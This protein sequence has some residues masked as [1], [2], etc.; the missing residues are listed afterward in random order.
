MLPVV[1]MI[2]IYNIFS[3]VIRSIL[4]YEMC[5]KFFLKMVMNIDIKLAITL[6]KLFSMLT[7]DIFVE[8]G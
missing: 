2:N 3:D 7:V 6:Y 5:S 4:E 8:L 1:V